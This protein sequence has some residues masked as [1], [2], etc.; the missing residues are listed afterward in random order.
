MPRK[1]TWEEHVGDFRKVHGDRYEYPVQKFEKTSSK[2]EIICQEHGD[3]SQTINSHKKGDGCP[4]CSGH[5]LKNI[6]EKILCDDGIEREIISKS[7]AKK[8]GLDRYFTGK[9]CSNNHIF[10]RCVDNSRCVVCKKEYAKEYWQQNKDSL[11]EHRQEYSKEY[12]QQNKESIRERMK[13][14]IRNRYAN[15]VNFTAS[16]ICRRILKRT[17]KAAQQNKEASTFKTLGYSAQDLKDSI[18]SKFLGGMSWDNFGDWHIDHKVSVMEHI[19]NGITDPAIINSLDN[20]Y[21]MWSEHN[22]SKSDKDLAEW[23]E[24]NPE[25]LEIYGH[26]LDEDF[27][28][29]EK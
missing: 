7:E 1:K 14:Y 12:R 23:L 19:R 26:W 10:E 13:R 11:K 20:L 22:L 8:K 4:Y 9:P 16:E 15:D 24:E 17:L 2:I 25:M 5:K 3:F 6:G 21:P 18:E 28:E 29:I 27:K